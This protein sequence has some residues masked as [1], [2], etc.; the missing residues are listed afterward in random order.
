MTAWRELA[1]CEPQVARCTSNIS[2]WNGSE[3]TR[4]SSPLILSQVECCTCSQ[5]RSNQEKLEW[6]LLTEQQ[7]MRSPLKAAARGDTYMSSARK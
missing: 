7:M 1:S 6:A 2:S 5:I 4:N 3:Y